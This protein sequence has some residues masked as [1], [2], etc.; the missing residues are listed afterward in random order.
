MQ[1]GNTVFKKL[2]KSKY[3]DCL[4]DKMNVTIWTVNR[5]ELQNGKHP[6]DYQTKL[7]REK[8]QFEKSCIL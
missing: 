6:D 1:Q 4:W 3:F 2:S 5:T 8:E 7:V